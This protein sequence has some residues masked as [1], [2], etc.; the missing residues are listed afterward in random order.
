MQLGIVQKEAPEG[1]PV[2][3][4][5]PVPGYRLVRRLGVG[6][7]GEVWSAEGPGGFPVALKIIRLEASRAA[8]H[9]RGLEIARAVRHPNLLGG[10][11]AWADD[12]RL[13]LALELA[14]GS[15][16][17]RFLEARSEGL[18][19]IPRDE[20]ID[21]LAEAAK[22]VDYLNE[23]RH[24]EGAR[25][26]IQHRDLKPQNILLVGG[27]VKVAD[28]GA[29][30]WME[31]AVT[32]HTGLQW[33]PAYAAPEFF[34]GAT[35]RNSDQYSLAVTY[36]HVRTGRLPF[37]GDPAFVMAG[38][39]MRSPDLSRLD[40]SERAVVARALAKRPED[41]WPS[42]RAFVEAI[43]AAA[44][45]RA[46]APGPV[47]KACLV[48]PRQI[49][50]SLAEA[51]PVMAYAAGA[52]GRADDPD[53]SAW[54]DELPSLD[55]VDAPTTDTA[56]AFGPDPA[57]NAPDTWAAFRSD[58]ARR[59]REMM[60]MA[61]LVVAGGVA[62]WAS[63]LFRGS[64]PARPSP[65]PP[66]PP[67]LAS[68]TPP[69]PPP[70]VATREVIP[71]GSAR[72]RP[73]LPG[74][75]VIRRVALRPVVPEPVARTVAAGAASVSSRPV[76]SYFG[77]T[78]ARLVVPLIANPTAPPVVSIVATWG[79]PE[80]V[81]SSS[82][83]ERAPSSAIEP[84]AVP[85]EEPGDGPEDAADPP[86][87][88]VATDPGAAEAPQ[89]ARP[90]P[91]EAAKRRGDEHLGRGELDAAIAGY[92][93]AIRAD[94]KL[95]DAYASRGEALVKKGD[96]ARAIADFDAALRL[97][98][99]SAPTLSDRGV[100]E[101]GRGDVF[102][103]IA[104]LDA[105]LGVAPG[106]AVIHYNRGIAYARLGDPAEARAEFDAALRLDPALALARSARDL[107]PARHVALARDV[108]HRSRPAARFASM[109][110]PPIPSVSGILP[111]PQDDR[112]T[113]MPPAPPVPV[114]APR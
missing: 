81:A 39:L 102:R 46:S 43:R 59:R 77:R 91:G 90:S 114:I 85:G 34:L 36:C 78:L 44:G 35:A 68:H 51:P 108:T 25:L 63:G 19:G 26:G 96:H 40:E 83:E 94:P 75:A 56:S 38:H 29:A 8:A 104:D 42:C 6:G 37:A 97:R 103:A 53:D 107:V 112:P 87:E 47:V 4:A 16:W 30:R 64:T 9:L 18:P 84:P 99:G 23:P 31:E 74:E 48:W 95:A 17:D 71:A 22:G 57:E 67:A 24:G 88:D 111:T 98:P 7:F 106:S 3:G 50:G 10:F 101:L 45:H 15:L 66:L 58:P 13:I 27:G 60:A 61:S 12:E 69:A 105:A 11:G 113:P 52:P 54:D 92:T 82:P 32:G 14:D 109:P 28:F 70:A 1:L 80:A 79:S 49:I 86:V 93:E 33:T 89:D 65:R 21:A 72:S 5:E 110:P 62:L 41:R 73:E 76:V 20:L 2:P 100:A 55:T